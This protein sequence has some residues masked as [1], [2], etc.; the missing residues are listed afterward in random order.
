MGYLI[1]SDM[2]LHDDYFGGCIAVWNSVAIVGAYV[3]ENVGTHSGSAH[4]FVS[5][6]DS[7]HLAEQVLISS[8]KVSIFYE[9]TAIVGVLFVAPHSSVFAKMQR[10]YLVY[11]VSPPSICLLSIHYVCRM[12]QLEEEYSNL[13]NYT[14]Y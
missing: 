9:D 10:V 2:K 5:N 7:P 8:A 12:E 3:D 6:R 1:G 11:D 14:T 4:I 13:D